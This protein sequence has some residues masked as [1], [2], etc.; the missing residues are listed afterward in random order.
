MPS[1]KGFLVSA[2][3]EMRVESELSVKGVESEM[4]VI[5]VKSEFIVKNAEKDTT[6]SNANEETSHFIIKNAPS[7]QSLSITHVNDEYEE[8]RLASTSFQLH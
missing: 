1:L 7:L 4:N 2:G 8:V 6:V 5:N 3:K